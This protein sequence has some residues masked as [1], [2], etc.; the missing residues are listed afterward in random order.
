MAVDLSWDDL[1]GVFKPFYFARN[2]QVDR[3]AMIE[4][5]NWLI[6]AYFGLLL[7]HHSRESYRLKNLV[8]LL[9]TLIDT[10]TNTKRTLDMATLTDI[11]HQL[12]A[13]DSSNWRNDLGGRV[14]NL[15]AKLQ[16]RFV[17]NRAGLAR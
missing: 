1:V 4:K 13:A 6:F 9:F 5:Y 11:A 17:E 2:Q 14:A 10:D 7:F 12:T 15:Y 8:Q 16:G 3:S